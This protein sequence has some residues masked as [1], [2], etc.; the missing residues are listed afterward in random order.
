MRIVWAAALL[1]IA[2]TATAHP[3]PFSYLDLHLDAGSIRGT[4]VVHDFDVA[5][6]LGLGQPETLLDA[7]VARD[8]EAALSALLA[9]RLRI[10]GDDRSIALQWEPLQTLP[11]RQSLRL[12]FRLAVATPGRLEVN[13][14]LFPYDENH[15]T[16]IN[17]YQAG[18]LKHQAILDAQRRS[19]T[20]YSGAL[21]GRWSVI[22]TFVQA[23]I[24]HIL[25]GPDH[26]LFL[27]GL[28]LL[29]GTVWRLATIVTAFTV[30]HS[31]TLSLAAL[32]L[33]R[34]APAIVEPA[35]ALSIVMVGVDNLLMRK[36]QQAQQIDSTK[37]NKSSQNAAA[38]LDLRPCLAALFGLVHGFGFAAVL[39]EFGLPSSA[40]GWSLAAFNIGVEIG[41]LAIVAAL[42]GLLALIK[43]RNPALA[44]RCILLGSM[45]VIAAGLCWFI[46]RVW[47]T[48]AV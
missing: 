30:G 17:I 27:L 12:P 32:D 44:Q 5:H 1:A 7:G 24:Q 2:C 16:F 6:E 21:Q 31:I 3:A 29:G 13:A 10:A 22:H 19:L 36:R 47:F 46:Q 45:F 39:L 33:V 14:L 41:Q 9:A 15:Q 28:L 40:L 8:S 42:A 38:A 25:I 35:I 11:E 34:M 23:G 48:T 4:L 18:Q 37:A 26:I 20:Y 43:H